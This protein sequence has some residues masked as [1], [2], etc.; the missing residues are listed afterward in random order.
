MQWLFNERVNIS[1]VPTIEATA[2]K[3]LIKLLGTEKNKN[4]TNYII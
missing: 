4:P 2:S 1:L 3:F